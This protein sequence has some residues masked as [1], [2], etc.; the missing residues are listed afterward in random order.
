MADSSTTKSID[1]LHQPYRIYRPLWL[2]TD[3]LYSLKRDLDRELESISQ[4]LLYVTNIFDKIDPRLNRP[5]EI[6]DIKTT[7]ADQIANLEARIKVLEA[8][9]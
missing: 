9:P 6:K 1:R 8:K 7:M 4:S 2:N 5:D 3:S